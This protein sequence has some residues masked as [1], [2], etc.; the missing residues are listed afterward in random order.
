M[1]MQGDYGANMEAAG[2][3]CAH[4]SRT[5]LIGV[6]FRGSG[7]FG[8]SPLFSDLKACFLL[9]EISLSLVKGGVLEPLPQEPND[10][11]PD[12][13]EALDR[14]LEE[15]RKLRERVRRAL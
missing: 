15:S 1:R 5:V 13:L 7:P 9:I 10:L 11:S 6:P 3:P 2:R 12:F 8:I 4:P 14:T